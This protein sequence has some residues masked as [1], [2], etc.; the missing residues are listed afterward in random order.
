MAFDDPSLAWLFTG[1]SVPNDRVVAWMSGSPGL[2]HAAV[3]APSRPS[4]FEHCAHYLLRTLEPLGIDLAFDH[5]PLA[6]TP[7]ASD[8]VLVHVGS[9][10]PTK[11]WPAGRF[12]EV[13]RA[14]QA[15]VRLVVGEADSA[16]AAA[17]EA[18]LSYKPPRLEHPPLDDLA[19]RLAGCRAYL[20][21]DS[22]V[23][24][25]A[26]LS[27]ARTVVL[28]GPSDPRIW[29]PL[30]P[31][32]HVLRFDTGTAEVVRLLSVNAPQTSQTQT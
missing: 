9:G 14:L 31:D 21:N 19:A 20:G 11:N 22:G 3:V 25:L 32:V 26:G 23:S 16:A 1:K 5:R 17:V 18:A 24:H 29:R 6:I 10:S 30:G 8:D 28:F 27:G 15:P 12:A 13:I 7:I 4:Q 2:S